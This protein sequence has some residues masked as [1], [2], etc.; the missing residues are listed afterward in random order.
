MCSSDL[1]LR[2]SAERRHGNLPGPFSA[3]ELAKVAMDADLMPPGLNGDDTAKCRQTIGTILKEL[4]PSSDHIRIDGKTLTRMV[5]KKAN[6][7]ERKVY[8]LSD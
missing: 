4:I 3:T 7:E 6:G 2:I 5:E 8:Q 1:M